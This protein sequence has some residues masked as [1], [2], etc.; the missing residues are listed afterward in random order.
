[1]RAKIISTALLL[2]ISMTQF[3]VLAFD[4]MTDGDYRAFSGADVVLALSSYQASVDSKT[5]SM[6]LREFMNL[7]HNNNVR[8][9]ASIID[10][11]QKKITA[12]QRQGVM[13]CIGAL[14]LN[15]N[16]HLNDETA[17]T[18]L[19]INFIYHILSVTADQR[20]DFIRQYNMISGS[21][22]PD[23]THVFQILS[24]C[25]QNLKPGI[26][27][28][29]VTNTANIREAFN[30]SAV[31]SLNFVRKIYQKN[32]SHL[33]HEILNPDYIRQFNADHSNNTRQLTLQQRW[34]QG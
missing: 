31:G 20:Q 5:E 29:I 32:E 9:T 13:S 2:G 8:P 18:D 22:I 26:V 25:R 27:E 19:V 21:V 6:P 3:N 7:F 24:F 34:L 23:V 10:A 30:I 16:N 14:V 28:Q 4:D 11:L 33:M 15:F 12:D 17:I 1:M